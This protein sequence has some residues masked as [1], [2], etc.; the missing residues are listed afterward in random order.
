M[1]V[2][3]KDCIKAWWYGIIDNENIQHDSGDFNVNSLS[4]LNHDPHTIASANS[5]GKT[6]FVSVPL[7][8]LNS[9]PNPVA[10]YMNVVTDVSVLWIHILFDT[11]YQVM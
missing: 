8:S 10:G 2:A 7:A 6:S 11:S 3:S 9:I 4:S 1:D 5:N